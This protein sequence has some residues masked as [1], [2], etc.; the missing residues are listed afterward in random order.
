MHRYIHQELAF[1]SSEAEFG[2]NGPV[3]VNV[4]VLNV[5]QQSPP[6][7]DHD[8]QASSGMMIL[9]MDFKMFGQMRN[10]PGQQCN[11]NLRRSCVGFMKFKAVNRLS[12]VYG[13]TNHT[14]LLLSVILLMK[15]WLFVYIFISYYG[16]TKTQQ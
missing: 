6:L 7:A 4:L 10:P 1:L 8:Q 16:F 12:L 11:L 13:C 14:F 2:D 15:S 9:C 3:A 5:I